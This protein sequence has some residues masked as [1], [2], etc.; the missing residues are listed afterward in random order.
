MEKKPVSVLQEYTMKNKYSLPDYLFETSD[1]P[2]FGF[3]CTVNVANI[4]MSGYGNT[5]QAAKHDSALKVL[6]K[7]GFL[8]VKYDENFND[9]NLSNRSGPIKN[10]LAVHSP[11]RELLNNYVG[12][13][14]EMAS[15]NRKNY[16]V[17]TEA[18]SLGP[19]RVHCSFLNWKTEG[20]AV[21]KKVAK[22]EAAKKM[23]EM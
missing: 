18:L 11:N 12:M 16:P 4:V 2:G 1:K 9:K 6:E 10:E 14:N 8:C 7:I 23:V 22:Q 19:F 3:K 20:I 13:L 17:Y 21:N 15:L 5:K